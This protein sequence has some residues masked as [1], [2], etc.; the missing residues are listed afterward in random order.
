MSSSTTTI[1]TAVYYQWTDAINNCGS[2]YD[3]RQRYVLDPPTCFQTTDD[4]GFWTYAKGTWMVEG[5]T[6]NLAFYSDAQCTQQ[7]GNW[8]YDLETCYDNEIV[9]ADNSYGVC[10]IDLTW[11]WY[12]I[13]GVLLIAAFC[14]ILARQRRNRSRNRSGYARTPAAA[15]THTVVVTNTQPQSQPQSYQAPTQYA[16]PQQYGAPQQ[17]PPPQQTYGQPVYQNPPA[18]QQPQDRNFPNANK[19]PTY[20]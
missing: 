15:S 12:T 4:F 10:R 8:P 17:Y 1:P 14:A 3:E 20:G 16:P 19:P 13:G 9:T 2:C 18:Y 11:V 6:V 7:T 5:K